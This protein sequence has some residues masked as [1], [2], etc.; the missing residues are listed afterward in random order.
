ML[1][2][3]VSYLWNKFREIVLVKLLVCIGVRMDVI[4]IVATIL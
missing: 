3:A 1:D 4:A 2:K